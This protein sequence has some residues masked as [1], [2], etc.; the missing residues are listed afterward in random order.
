MSHD[1]PTHA[2]RRPPHARDGASSW[3]AWFTTAMMCGLIVFMIVPENLDYESLGSSMPQSG[4]LISR[5]VWIALL[6]G[7]AAIV[8]RNLRL[9]SGVVAGLSPFLL[10]FL[11]LACA[12]VLWSAEPDFTLRRL[13]RLA[14]IVLVSLAFVLIPRRNVQDILRPVITTML[15]GSV[16]WVMLNPTS[17]LERSSASELAGAWHGLATQKNGLGSLAA[18]G[19][20]LWLHAWLAREARWPAIALGGSVSLLCLFCSRS[21]TSLLATAFTA[22]FMTFLLRSP[23][24]LR[25]YMPWLIGLFTM[26]LLLYSLAVLRLV[27][28][29]A[30]LLRPIEILTGKDPSFSGRTAI[31]GIVTENIARHPFLG[32]GYGAYWIGPL[33]GT[34]AYEQVAR[35]YFYPAEAHNGY[36]DIIN[37]LGA[38]GGA[39]LCGYLLEYLRQSLSVFSRARTQGTLYLGL[40]FEQL[41]ANMSESR[42]LNVLCVE[43]VIMTLATAALARTQFEY[44]MQEWSRRHDHRS[45]T[46]RGGS[47]VG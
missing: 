40:F 31:W 8:V 33:T 47:R 5:L 17:A 37:D 16:A 45:D 3:A 43:F 35:L 29:L 20:L 36:L 32:G 22:P 23:R 21:S 10:A 7:S 2:Q 14:S 11:A 46:V 39:C 9:A 26:G 28:G 42:W 1:P 25:R 12:S 19:T 15:L 18:I 24:C 44:R 30:I 27:P 13:I 6:F 38:L 34:A 4:N 41:M